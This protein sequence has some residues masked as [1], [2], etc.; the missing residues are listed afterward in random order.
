MDIVVRTAPREVSYLDQTL[1]SIAIAFPTSR[2]HITAEPGI[3]EPL[4]YPVNEVH[5]NPRVLGVV[6]NFIKGTRF[7]LEGKSEWLMLCEDDIEFQA[8]AGDRVVDA[9][10]YYTDYPNLGFITP[11]CAKPHGNAGLFG[12]DVFNTSTLCG[13]LCVILHRSSAATILDTY[14]RCTRVSL[15]TANRSADSAFGKVVAKLDLVA[16]RHCPTLVQHIGE[17]SSI[18]ERDSLPPRLLENRRPYLAWNSDAP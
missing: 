3:A 14:E 15:K 1:D 8:D 4:E 2:V 9:L 10:R 6:D 18:V 11:Y 13:L 16:I 12:W 5:V 7:L 17:Y